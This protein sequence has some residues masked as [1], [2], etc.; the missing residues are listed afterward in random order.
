MVTLRELRSFF[1]ELKNDEA[2]YDLLKNHL[3]EKISIKKLENEIECIQYLREIIT[4]KKY[5]NLINEF[6]LKSGSSNF[7]SII[8][9]ALLRGMFFCI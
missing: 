2:E 9:K 3:Y 4:T 8:M 1:D 5:E 6:E 7:Q